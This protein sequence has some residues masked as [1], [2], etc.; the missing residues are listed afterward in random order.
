MEYMLHHDPMWLALGYAP[1]GPT[2][3]PMNCV[4][5]LGLVQWELVELAIEFV[6]AVL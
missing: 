3:Q 1:R 4:A 5:T 2:D 6:S